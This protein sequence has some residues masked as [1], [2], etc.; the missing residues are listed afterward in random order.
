MLQRVLLKHEAF[1]GPL[2][3]YGPDL[4]LGYA[5][6]YRASSETG[7]GQWGAEIISPNQD[8]WGADHCV[9]SLSVPGVIFSNLGLHGIEK[10]SY[11]DIPMLTIGKALK[12]SQSAPPPPSIAAGEDQEKL[13]ERLKSLGYL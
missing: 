3:P 1:Q 9:D 6:G 2:T 11:L 12:Q 7:L 13:E 8:H 10:P 5:P 4:V